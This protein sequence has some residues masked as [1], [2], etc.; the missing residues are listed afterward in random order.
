[1]PSYACRT[2]GRAATPGDTSVRNTGERVPHERAPLASGPELRYGKS[3]Q[4]PPLPENEK[5]RLEALRALQVLDSEPDQVIDDLT[6]L[7]AEVCGTPFALVSLVDEKRLWF[8]SKL[9][10]DVHDSD[11]SV[12]L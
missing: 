4:T 6:R 7:A 11:R 10:L 2:P 9:G 8:K 5:E 1:M 3:V 12:S